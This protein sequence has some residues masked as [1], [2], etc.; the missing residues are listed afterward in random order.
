[1]GNFKTRSVSRQHDDWFY[2]EQLPPTLRKALACSPFTWDSKWFLDRWKKSPK[3]LEECL[4]LLKDVN[5]AHA[6]KPV[7]IRVGNK[8]KTEKSP[9]SLHGVKPLISEFAS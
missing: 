2:F 6:K 5:D 7:K 9:T 1:M 4:R 8:W 3:G